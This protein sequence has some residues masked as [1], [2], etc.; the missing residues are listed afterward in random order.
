M[1]RLILSLLAGLVFTGMAHGQGTYLWT[2][3]GNQNFF[4][5]SFE[6]TA[7]EMVPGS[8]FTSQLFSNSITVSSLDGIIYHLTPSGGALG[9]FNPPLG[10][11]LVLFDEATTSRLSA[12]VVPS[13]GALIDEFSNLP[14]G[15]NTETGFWTVTAIPEPSAGLLIM[16]GALIA[17]AR[18]KRRA[19]TKITPSSFQ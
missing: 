13:Q 16:L 5:A 9:K 1:P 4:Q 15:R 11:N 3:H 10:L 6:V 12:T 19:L 17:D 8:L 2:W 18:R 14:Q 7:A